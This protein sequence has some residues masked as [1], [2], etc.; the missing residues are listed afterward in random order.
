MRRYDIWVKYYIISHIFLGITKKMQCLEIS[1]LQITPSPSKVSFRKYF[2]LACV[3]IS[4]FGS[5]A[6]ESATHYEQT[7]PDL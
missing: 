6:L 4:S 3:R 7:N 5:H 2:L 1:E